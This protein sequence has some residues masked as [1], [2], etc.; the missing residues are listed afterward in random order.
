MCPESWKLQCTQ[1]APSPRPNDGIIRSEKVDSVKKVQRGKSQTERVKKQIDAPINSKST[2][3][4]I[5]RNR[6]HI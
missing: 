6:E 4:E 2:E 5:D 3:S 1:A